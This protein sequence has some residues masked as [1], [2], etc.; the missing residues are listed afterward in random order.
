MFCFTSSERIGIKTNRKQ[1]IDQNNGRNVNDLLEL[2]SR[3]TAGSGVGPQST[4]GITI[5]QLYGTQKQIITQSTAHSQPNQS[6]SPQTPQSQALPHPPQ[7]Q[8]SLKHPLPA[9]PQQQTNQIQSQ[10]QQLVAQQQC[11]VKQLIQ[12]TPNSL[13]GAK[14]LYNYDGKDLEEYIYHCFTNYL[15]VFETNLKLYLNLNSMFDL[16]LAIWVLFSV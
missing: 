13:P 4:V 9:P 5:N 14:S 15:S 16:C 12:T 6:Q 1:S 3:Q 2:S 10:Q 8:I 7:H 11:L